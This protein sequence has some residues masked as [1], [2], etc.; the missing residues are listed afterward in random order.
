MMALAAVL[1]TAV[2][3]AQ[4]R[5][6]GTHSQPFA[7]VYQSLGLLYFN[8]S[9]LILPWTFDDRT[10]ADAT[11]Q[12]AAVILGG[13]CSIGQIVLGA[14]LQSSLFTGFGLTFVGIHLFT[15]YYEHFWNSLDKGLFFLIGG[16]VL[17]GIGMSLE[18]NLKRIS[19]GSHGK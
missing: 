5:R 9:V 16:L 10:S 8:M 17:F 11:L 3:L 4:A 15:R 7:R 2:G 19:G 6:P 18:R 1:G 14:R 13:L 12:T